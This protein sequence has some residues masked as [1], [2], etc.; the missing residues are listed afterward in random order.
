MLPA[1]KLQTRFDLVEVRGDQS[2]QVGLMNVLQQIRLTAHGLRR[3]EPSA[4]RLVVSRC[5]VPERAWRGDKLLDSTGLPGR[6]PEVRADARGDELVSR[7]FMQF[8]D[9][10]AGD[11]WFQKP[12]DLQPDPKR[13][14]R[15]FIPRVEPRR[16]VLHLP[17]C[18]GNGGRRASLDSC[19]RMQAGI[20]LSTEAHIHGIAWQ[21]FPVVLCHKK[22]DHVV[23]R[24]RFFKCL[25]ESKVSGVAL[26]DP[27]WV[28]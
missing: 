16:R 12:L 25:R 11:R 14:L 10:A 22:L 2:F 5:R 21:D 1:D 23:M 7:Q 26:K 20:C 15:L 13:L 19:R 3:S 17:V 28:K 6:E 8:I 24:W 18:G 27:I 9:V 4:A